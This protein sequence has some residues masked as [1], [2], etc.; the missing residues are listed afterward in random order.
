MEY[1]RSLNISTQPVIEPELK[2]CMCSRSEGAPSGP[3]QGGTRDNSTSSLMSDRHVTSV[4]RPDDTHV[5]RRPS[6]VACPTEKSTFRQITPVS[7]KSPTHGSIQR[8][9]L[10]LSITRPYIDYCCRVTPGTR[11]RLS[12]YY[13]RLFLISLNID[14]AFCCRVTP[15]SR[16]RLSFYCSRLFL[17]SLNVDVAFCCRVT[18]GSREP[19]WS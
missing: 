10:N 4:I 19:A 11:D 16:D 18:P 6:H 14:V 5:T 15:G 1:F 12:F 9:R 2:R 13:S 8:C 7:V 17:I 3:Q